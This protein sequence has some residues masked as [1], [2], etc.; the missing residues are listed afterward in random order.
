MD[1]NILGLAGWRLHAGLQNSVLIHD[2]L[3]Q[4]LLL[5][6]ELAQLLPEEK[7]TEHQ[8]QVAEW[9][10][11]FDSS[12]TFIVRESRRGRSSG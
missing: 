10:I 1:I 9:K 4:L 12:P 7:N 2:L 6:T 8:N 11:K 3:H 5:P